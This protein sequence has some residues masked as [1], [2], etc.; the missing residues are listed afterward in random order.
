MK[1][2]PT[3]CVATTEKDAGLI[4]DCKKIPEDLKERLFQVPI[5]ISFLSE[6]EQQVFEASLLGAIRPW[7]PA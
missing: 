4:L 5:E 7:A 1:S 2:F 3:A 6:L